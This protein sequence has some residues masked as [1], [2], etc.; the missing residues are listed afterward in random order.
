M[1]ASAFDRLPS[2]LVPMPRVVWVWGTAAHLVAL[3]GYVTAVGVALFA[4][5]APGLGLLLPFFSSLSMLIGAV[6]A[7]VFERMNP[8]QAERFVVPI[9]SGV[10]AGESIIGVVVA[11]LNNFVF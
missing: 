1:S 8:K 4:G 10:I 2:H 7:W 5:E 3:A 9:S 11:G 6:A